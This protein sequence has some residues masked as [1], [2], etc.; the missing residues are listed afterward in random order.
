MGIIKWIAKKIMEEELLKEYERGWE[1]GV[2][3]N[4]YEPKTCIPISTEYWPTESEYFG[5]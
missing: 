2:I 4:M 3:Q 1:S 5:Y